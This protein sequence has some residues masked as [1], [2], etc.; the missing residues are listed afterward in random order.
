M[1]FAIDVL[2]ERTIQL[3][4]VGLDAWNALQVRVAGPHVV[5]GDEKTAL[6]V[7]GDEAL[8]RGS[9]ADS[10]FDDFDGHPFGGDAVL[11]SQLD[12]GIGFGRRLAQGRDVEVDEK[13]KIRVEPGHGGKPRDGGFPTHAIELR[14]LLLSAGGVEK[15][16]RR[17]H[18]AAI[19]VG[20][21]RQ[22]LEPNDLLLPNG[23]DGLKVTS[24]IVRLQDGVNVEFR[25]Q[26]ATSRCARLRVLCV[27]G[28]KSLQ[29]VAA[30]NRTQEHRRRWY[31]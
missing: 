6:A 1:V 3:D 20:G 17:N 10:R 7:V 5:E 8:K 29:D 14:G 9:V 12:E 18:L 30:D 2:D 16:A 23:D 24:Q 4:D 11:L 26:A 19:G 31:D 25:I 27:H 15:T 21:A 13:N 28:G 22:R